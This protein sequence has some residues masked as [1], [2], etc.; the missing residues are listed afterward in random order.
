MRWFVRLTAVAVV[1]AASSVAPGVAAAVAAHQPRLAASSVAPGAAA[2]V[3]AHQP[4]LAASSVAPGVAA[5]VAAHQPRLA[6]SS[7]AP[8]AAAAVAAHQR[9]LAASSVAPGVAAAVAA[10]QPRAVLDPP[11]AGALYT[12]G[13]D[14]RYLLGGSW[15]FASD[16]GDTGRAAGLP[17][18]P[19]T[20]GWSPVTVPNAWNA[21]D[22][23]VPS[24]AGTIAW[25]RRDFRVPDASPSLAWIVRF[26]SVN[27][28]ARV[29]LNGRA[30][31]SNVGAYL[32]FEFP[33]TG[34]KRRGV[35]HLVIRVDNRRYNPVVG[36]QPPSG[37]W[38]YGGLIGEVY[39]RRVD[40]VDFENVVVRPRLPCRR[41]SA[42][43]ELQ[44]DVHNYTGAQQLVHVTGRF[45]ALSI[46]LGSHSIPAGAVASF[47]GRGGLAH[48]RLWSPRH[49]NLYRATLAATAMLDP[50]T[51]A[52]GMQPAPPTHAAG[53]TVLSGVRSIRVTH[54][55]QL[56]LNGRA[57]NFRGVAIHEDALGRGAALNNAD[58]AQ[59]IAL[60][61]D[62]G[63]T[64]L[65]G[66]YPLHPELEELADRAG[67]LLWS[68]IPIYQ[69]R[70]E[71]L[72]SVAFTGYERTQLTTNILANRNH[73][74]VVVWSIANELA[75]SPGPAQAS[76]IASQSA[77]ARQLDPTRPVGIAFAGNPNA[78]CQTAYAPLDVLGVNDYFGWYV[79]GTGDIADRDGLSGYLDAVRGC[80]PRQAIAIT[81][82]GAEANRDGPVEEKGTYEF[83][84]GWA[85]FHLGV[86]ASKPWLV[87][88]IYFT[89]R[90]FYVVPSWAGGD[91]WPNPPMHQKGLISYRGAPKPAYSVV[92]QIYR[93]AAQYR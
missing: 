79:G 80:Y 34:L 28:R 21:N 81:E 29:W 18:N 15:L 86:F 8:G 67:I 46:D 13:P 6:A 69:L 43:V 36:P 77:L 55:G 72:R 2:A 38:N 23:G 16:P 35:N 41:C 42:T 63:A 59:L 83:Q 48:P 87:G 45:G 51:P 11:T 53:Y 62:V 85:A 78:G 37:W 17:A 89:L 93:T 56:L 92:Q 25:Y 52:P 64:A 54:R 39:L 70:E 3:A 40:R 12:D 26:E 75:T 14:G 5:A 71:Q 7:V 50:P 73:P 74:S 22:H 4:R 32:P 27:F 19:S 61:R 20:A 88:A 84:S 24:M 76:Y 82:F 31:G 49:P 68:E 9:R 10:H 60:T 33:L 66:H 44:T 57:V 65:R 1:L 47:A 90:E 30:L 58:R 91:P